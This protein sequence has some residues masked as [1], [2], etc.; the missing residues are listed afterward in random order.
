M[1]ESLDE[2][3]FTSRP[4][5]K[6]RAL[7]NPEGADVFTAVGAQSFISKLLSRLSPGFLPDKTVNRPAAAFGPSSMNNPR[8]QKHLDTLIAVR[9][10]FDLRTTC[11]LSLWQP[12]KCEHQPPDC[13]SEDLVPR[14]NQMSL[15]FTSVHSNKNHQR[16]FFNN[17]LLFYSL[18]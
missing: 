18:F 8:P 16:L 9:C 11:D 10:S 5:D 4:T 14:R 12:E 17:N 7:H 2:N 3:I 13:L 6:M 1:I 15:F